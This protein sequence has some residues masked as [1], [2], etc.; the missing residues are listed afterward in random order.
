MADNGE[1]A[2]L[3]CGIA[4]QAQGIGKLRCHAQLLFLRLRPFPYF[5]CIKQECG[6]NADGHVKGE[7]DSPPHPEDVCRC[8]PG[9]QNG[10]HEGSNGLDKL[11]ER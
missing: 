1:E 8:T 10:G 6:D 5:R 7:K 4:Q 2:K 9:R 3:N 11:A